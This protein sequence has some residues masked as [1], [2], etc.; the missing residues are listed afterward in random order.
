MSCPEY[1]IECGA[2]IADILDARTRDP[3]TM[4]A[5]CMRF[6]MGAGTCA[7]AARLA[8]ASSRL[9]LSVAVPYTDTRTPPARAPPPPPTTSWPAPPPS[10]SPSSA[11]ASAPP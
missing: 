6:D 10:S 8:L 3:H 5:Y 2:S 7:D 4:P 1:E 11:S 9:D